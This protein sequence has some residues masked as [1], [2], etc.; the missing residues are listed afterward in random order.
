MTD[1]DELLRALGAIARERAREESR[2]EG[3]GGRA[4]WERLAGGAGSVD[5]AL[6][7]GLADAG[8]DDEALS[9]A[10]ARALAELLRPGAGA[11]DEAALALRMAGVLAQSTGSG[12]HVAEARQEAAP[13]AAATIDLGA[14]R[15]RRRWLGLGGVSGGI[16]AA[17]AAVMLWVRSGDPGAATTTTPLVVELPEYG[18]VARNQTV[19]SERGEPD[20]GIARY[21]AESEIDW[22]IAPEGPI[23]AATG[24]VI[25]V[26]GTG[27]EKVVRPAAERSEEGA[28]RIRGRVDEVLGLAAG[29]YTLRFLIGPAEGLPGEIA[30]VDGALA[31]GGVRE[32]TPRYEVKILE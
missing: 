17:A 27:A 4:A 5:E 13:A 26:E 11:G 14:A 22:V 19:Q 1:D 8:E 15:A 20:E 3:A 21:R 7:S 29:R 18:F 24:V 12:G 31:R 32:A 16:L 9:E 30:A 28:L 2:G 10:E 25:L 6:A 23:T